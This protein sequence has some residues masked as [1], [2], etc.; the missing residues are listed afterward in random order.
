MKKNMWFF[1]LIAAL[2]VLGCPNPA[3]APELEPRNTFRALT[4]VPGGG[5]IPHMAPLSV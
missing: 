5:R 4:A 3:D 2:L 1:A